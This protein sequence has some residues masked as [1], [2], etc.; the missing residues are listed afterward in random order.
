MKKKKILEYRHYEV[1]YDFP[2]LALFGDDWVRYY[3]DANV[4]HFHNHLE[5][6]Y[7]Y[8]GNGNMCIENNTRRFG[9]G[10]FTYIP[11]NIL[12]STESDPG[13]KSKWEYLFIDLDG[14]LDFIDDRMHHILKPI[15][16]LIETKSYQLN[17]KEQE[18]MAYAVLKIIRS[19][20]C[21][22]SNYEISIRGVFL[23]FLIDISNLAINIDL[24]STPPKSKNECR[25]K[26]ALEYISDGYYLPIKIMELSEL[27]HMSETHFRRLFHTTM[28]VAPLDYINAVRIHSACSLL[29]ET[30]DTVFNIAM[31]T[32]FSTI[33]TFNRNFAKVMKTTPLKWRND[34]INIG[35]SFKNYSIHYL[36]G[37]LN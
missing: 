19:I 22:Y 8:W 17:D 13:T 37:S 10:T 31:R 15:M 20:K 4:L 26:P 25:L 11:K 21:G 28:N 29:K 16:P 3:E 18:E 23:G 5:I 6:G 34:P 12:H 2:V 32:G 24:D 35:T 36:E 27:C 14:L 7:C 1:P 30:E 33:S 9:P